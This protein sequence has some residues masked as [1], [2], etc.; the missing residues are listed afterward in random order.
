MSNTALRRVS[1][2]RL[3]SSV[4]I[5][6]KRSLKTRLTLRSTL[7]RETSRPRRDAWSIKV[8]KPRIS[9]G[10]GRIKENGWWGGCE[11]ETQTKRERITL[12]AGAMLYSTLFPKHLIR[13]VGK[14]PVLSTPAHTLYFQASFQRLQGRFR[15]LLLIWS[16]TKHNKHKP[17]FLFPGVYRIWNCRQVLLSPEIWM[18]VCVC[19]LYRK[20]L[21]RRLRH[22]DKSKVMCSRG[23][24]I[25]TPIPAVTVG[26]AA[27]HVPS[28]AACLKRGSPK[29][30]GPDFPLHPKWM[31]CVCVLWVCVYGL[32]FPCWRLVLYCSGPE[33]EQHTEEMLNIIL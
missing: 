5:V 9:E 30:L 15:S 8:C 12:Q 14:Q 21:K 22:T 23:L 28:H 24:T 18:C 16:V 1:L 31:L 27:Q 33:N 26:A 11:E 32:V 7:C 10:G 20:P 6:L 4:R 2:Y 29:S 25:S 13:I 3:S 19:S 17:V